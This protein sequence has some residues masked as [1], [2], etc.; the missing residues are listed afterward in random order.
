ME[1]T[2]A[3]RKVRSLPRQ[4]KGCRSDQKAEAKSRPCK[5]SGHGFLKHRF[6]P[7][8]DISVGLLKGRVIMETEFFASLSNLAAIY[9]FEPLKVTNSVYPLNISNAF[10]HAA[11]AVRSVNADLTLMMIQD[12]T[13]NACL[14]TAKPYDLR[15]TLFY[16]PVRPLCDMLTHDR[17]RPL[18]DL[19]FSV[20]AY[21]Y[22]V[23]KVPYYRDNCTYLNGTYEMMKEW[24]EDSAGEYEEEDH[25]EQVASFD[26][27]YQYGDK[28]K[29]EI[30]QPAHLNSFEMRLRQF[31]PVDEKEQQLHKVCRKFF[32]LYS[33][34]PE[35]AVFDNVHE[36][37]IEPQEED[38]IYTE[39]LVSFFW[40]YGDS[41]Y[42]SLLETINC[43]FQEK[44]ITDEPTAM[45][46]FDVPQQA[47][48]LHQL[49][50]EERLFELI[51]ELIDLL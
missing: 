37:I 26:L 40:D 49:D 30:E 38:R 18:A 9:N 16:I 41:L 32:A 34:H 46:L 2:S 42:G 50:F 44:G 3:I 36:G 51:T 33:D 4:A 11:S 31:K 25:K 29:A 20:Y 17:D 48:S 35:R 43:E 23:V 14:A 24:L 13:H 7:L 19:L 45:Q 21:L 10:R 15:S 22:K 1:T 27:L 39:Q 8:T 28:V 5:F 6:L 47:V 12:G